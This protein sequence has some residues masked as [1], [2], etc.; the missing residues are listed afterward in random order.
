MNKLQQENLKVIAQNNIDLSLAIGLKIESDCKHVSDIVQTKIIESQES[1]ESKIN[2][3]DQKIINNDNIKEIILKNLDEQAKHI[4]DNIN[5]LKI[6]ISKSSIIEDGQNPDEIKNLLV[7]TIQK[8]EENKNQVLDVKKHITPDTKI[9]YTQEQLLNS[10]NKPIN[11]NSPF[12][13]LRS[14]NSSLKDT[15]NKKLNEIVPE[16]KNINLSEQNFKT[17]TNLI[18]IPNQDNIVIFNT[19]KQY[20]VQ[21]A[22]DGIIFKEVGLNGSVKGLTNII[23]STASVISGLVNLDGIKAIVLNSLKGV[24]QEYISGTVT[25][26]TLHGLKILLSSSILVIQKKDEIS[27]KPTPIQPDLTKSQLLGKSV[28]ELLRSFYDALSK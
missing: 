9:N 18:Q 2:N 12:P 17:E 20:L 15:L 23:S 10:L 25:G 21:K 13:V 27:S 19:D 4:Q 14:Y 6:A 1:I 22:V 16:S 24:L 11:F 28:G 7:D 3:M 8:L 26:A 5:N